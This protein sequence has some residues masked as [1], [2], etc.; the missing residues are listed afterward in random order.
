[1]WLRL[2]RYSTNILATHVLRLIKFIYIILYIDN[3]KHTRAKCYIN[4]ELV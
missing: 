3:I 2:D 4:N 1:M